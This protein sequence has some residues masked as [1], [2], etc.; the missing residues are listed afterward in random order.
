MALIPTV[1]DLTELGAY[2]I[3]K[4]RHDFVRTGAGTPG[5]PGGAYEAV[6]DGSEALN[7]NGSVVAVPFGWGPAT[8][9]GERWAL[10][11]INAIISDGS[12]AFDGVHF[13]ET[14]PC[15]SG[16]LIQV[17]RR[18]T[19]VVQTFDTI[20]ANPD[21]AHLAGADV[22]VLPFGKADDC[23]LVKVEF[24]DHHVLILDGSQN[25]VLQVTIQDDLTALTAFRMYC[26]GY[27]V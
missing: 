9:S 12:Q 22:V 17:N 13:G 24:R 16:V 18:S 1:Y 23:M 21:W 6:I 20:L 7:V 25:D 2:D 15:N 8:G 5:F 10:L 27:K 14:G 11:S 26:W 4:L 19:G 3:S